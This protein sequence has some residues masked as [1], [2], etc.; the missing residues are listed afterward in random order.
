MTKPSVAAYLRKMNNQRVVL[1]VSGARTIEDIDDMRVE[2]KALLAKNNIPLEKLEESDTTFSIKDT[3]N[4][5]KKPQLRR[6][7]YGTLKVRSRD[8][9]FIPEGMDESEGMVGSKK[10]LTYAPDMVKVEK[11]INP[12]PRIGGLISYELA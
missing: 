2:L 10:G 4:F 7:Q 3:V 5:W 8:Y 9:V 12:N 1:R 6:E 11:V